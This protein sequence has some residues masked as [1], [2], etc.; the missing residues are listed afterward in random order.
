M[1]GSPKEESLCSE[2]CVLERPCLGNIDCRELNAER[3]ANA[4]GSLL[5]NVLGSPSS[6]ARKCSEV[7]LERTQVADSL[8]RAALKHLQVARGAG[9][10]QIRSEN[11]RERRSGDSRRVYAA[12]HASRKARALVGALDGNQDPRL[13]IETGW[14]ALNGDRARGKGWDTGC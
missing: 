8:T 3:P 4:Q 12:D 1:R 13:S 14:R 11:H 10:L 9:S 6:E 2:G 7:C 5:D